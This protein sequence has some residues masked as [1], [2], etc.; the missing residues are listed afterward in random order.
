MSKES[1]EHLCD[2]IQVTLSP[3]DIYWLTDELIVRTLKREQ[4]RP[5][6]VEELRERVAESERQI[7]EGRCK[8]AEESLAEL[9]AMF[10]GEEAMTE[11]YENQHF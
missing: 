4:P 1:L 7:A 5:Y 2:Y 8:S 11:P 6:T 9:E 10:A 3:E